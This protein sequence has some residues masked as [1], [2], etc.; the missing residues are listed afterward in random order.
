MGTAEGMLGGSLLRIAIVQ[1]LIAPAALVVQEVPRYVAER[2]RSTGFESTSKAL[3][4]KPQGRSRQKAGQCPLSQDPGN[5][6][7]GALQLLAVVSCTL[8][9][10]S[11]K[12]QFQQ[13]APGPRVSTARHRSTSLLQCA[14]SDFVSRAKVGCGASNFLS[15]QLV[16]SVVC[17]VALCVLQVVS[18]LPSSLHERGKTRAAL[19][20]YCSNNAA[21]FLSGSRG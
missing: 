21:M 13:K 18:R 17:V 11:S 5:L 9:Q 12:S 4:L 10:G 7:P 1:D 6:A 2:L 8:L 3:S 19:T 14:M 16:V 15:F 20:R